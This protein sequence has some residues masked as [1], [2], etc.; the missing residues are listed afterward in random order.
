MLSESVNSA[1][2]F[3]SERSSSLSRIRSCGH[4]IPHILDVW[5]LQCLNLRRITSCTDSEATKLRK[6]LFFVGRK[7]LFSVNM[8]VL[9]LTMNRSV[10]RKKESQMI[11]IKFTLINFEILSKIKT[12][13]YI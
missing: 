11:F 13:L 5:E 8:S 4:T 1:A 9:L 2:L 10:K 6:M 3:R 7:A 12:K